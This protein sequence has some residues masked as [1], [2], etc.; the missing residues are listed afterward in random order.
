MPRNIIGSADHGLSF[1]QWRVIK[2]CIS[3]LLESKY[4]LNSNEEIMVSMEEFTNSDGAIRNVIEQVLNIRVKTVILTN[5]LDIIKLRYES[6]HRKTRNRNI[7]FKSTA[8]TCLNADWRTWCNV[9]KM[10]VSQPS[11]SYIITRSSN[12]SLLHVP[13]PA[14]EDDNIITRSSNRSLLHVPVPASEDDNHHFSCDNT[15]RLDLP[16]KKSI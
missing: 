14:S 13:V 3:R 6:N 9:D 8:L 2:E 11:I 12:R 15:R 7:L 16:C 4:S 10:E 1:E 5:R